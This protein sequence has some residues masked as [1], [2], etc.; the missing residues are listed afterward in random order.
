MRYLVL[1]LAAS[2]ACAAPRYFIDIPATATPQREA[3]Y[4]HTHDAANL[5]A[6][7]AID[8]VLAWTI[9]KGPTDHVGMGQRQICHSTVDATLHRLTQVCTDSVE[10]Y[11]FQWR[12]GNNAPVYRV[13]TVL[14]L[15]GIYRQVS[16]DYR[17]S[18]WLFNVGGSFLRNIGSFAVAVARGH[19]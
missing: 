17:E 16:P 6:G 10:T 13:A 4:Y 18:G 3:R 14:V 1:L 9:F 19:F 11:T 15:G 2:T 7:A 8:Q 12:S 5:A